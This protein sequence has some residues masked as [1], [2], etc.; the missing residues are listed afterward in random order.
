MLRITEDAA[1]LFRRLTSRAESS[2]AAGMRIVVNPIHGSLSMGVAER[3]GPDDQVHTQDE[4][5][6][7]LSPAAANKLDRRTIHAEITEDR[8]VFYLA[9]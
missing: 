3:P 5:R 4:A 6:V 1:R 9:D 7:F 2:E 8:S